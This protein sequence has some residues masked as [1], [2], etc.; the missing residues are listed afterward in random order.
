[1]NAWLN[2]LRRYR[3]AVTGRRNIKTLVR[4]KHN[5]NQ[6]IKIILG[7]SDHSPLN[8]DW[9]NTDIPQFDIFLVQLKLTTCWPNM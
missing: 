5:N 2:K 6:A 1:M 8:G 7:S 4:Q 9:I 3:W